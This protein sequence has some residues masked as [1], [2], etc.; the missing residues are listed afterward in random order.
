MRAGI[1]LIGGESRRMGR[2]KHALTLGGLTFLERILQTLAGET[3]RRFIVAAADQTVETALGELI[4]DR[5]PGRGPLHG[6]ALGLEAALRAGCDR[7]WVT[8]VDTPMLA[9]ALIRGMFDA[10][11]RN[12]P[13]ADSREHPARVAIPRIA[14]RPYPLHGSY[15]TELAG[16][17]HDELETGRGSL[18][19]LIERIGREPPPPGVTHGVPVRTVDE[20]FLDRVDPDRLS[21]INVNDPD[22]L[23]RLRQ[24]FG[25]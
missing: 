5:L 18:T 13:A 10:L 16:L 21:L 12:S 11:G 20:S 8:A 15:R 14:G 19:G 9:P 4:R 1:V 17:A 3:D 2:P 6:L 24:R 23:E 7:A 22:D 25:E